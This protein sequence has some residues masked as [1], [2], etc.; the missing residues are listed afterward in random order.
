SVPG[1]DVALLVD[2]FIVTKVDYANGPAVRIAGAEEAEMRDVAGTRDISG[3]EGVD[4]DRRMSREP[5]CV[6][7]AVP[8][9]AFFFCP[10]RERISLSEYSPSCVIHDI[11]V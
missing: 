4:S 9:L 5:S 8:D 7:S 10:L 11:A 3:G 2:A 1:Q 6:P